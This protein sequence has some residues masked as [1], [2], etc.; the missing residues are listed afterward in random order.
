MHFTLPVRLDLLAFWHSGACC[1]VARAVA[2]FGSSSGNKYMMIYDIIVIYYVVFV[3]AN[4]LFGCGRT[5]PGLGLHR[6]RVVCDMGLGQTKT[7][8]R[9]G[10]RAPTFAT[11]R[12]RLGRRFNHWGYT[13]EPATNRK[14][15]LAAQSPIAAGPDRS[16]CQV[17][18]PLL[19]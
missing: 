7:T 13:L 2:S 5:E 19:H 3:W 8:K 14:R 9:C 17:L 4:V 12:T 6:S 10:H 18:R 16:T 11:Q 1:A 15:D